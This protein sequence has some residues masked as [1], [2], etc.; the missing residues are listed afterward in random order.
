MEKEKINFLKVRKAADKIW[1]YFDEKYILF[2]QGI[3]TE[4]EVVADEE[5][6]KKDIEQIEEIIKNCNK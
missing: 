4:E 5:E 3:P 6:R 2:L 1:N